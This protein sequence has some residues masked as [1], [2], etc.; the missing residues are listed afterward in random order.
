VTG[1]VA[2]PPALW[3]PSPE[4]VQNANLTRYL[5][6]LEQE[7]N[8]RFDGYDELWRWSTDDLAG[9]WSS[10][11]DHYAVSATT[12]PERI[13]SDHGMP[14]V[15]WF[16]GAT[17]NYAEHILR[18]GR[19]SAIAVLYA[20]EGEPLRHLTRGQLRD[21]VARLAQGL[22][23]MAVRPGD[24]VAAFLPNGAEAIV[25]VLACASL[26]AI[27]SSCSPD[28][29]VRS[30]VDR[31]AQIEPKVLIAADGYRYGG[32][33][34]DRRDVVER[35]RAEIPS[36]EHTVLVTHLDPDAS[37][38][39]ATSWTDLTRDPAELVF[40]AVPFEHP[41]WI[42]YSSGT[43]GVPKGIV[44][45][46][47]GMLL[48]HLKVTHLHLDAQA[49]DRVFWFTTTGWMMWNFLVGCLLTDA[50]IVLYDGNPG[51]PTLDA[52]W[53]LA[54]Q[55]EITTFGT[56]A[57]YIAGCINDDVE[58]KQGRNLRAL[59]AVGSTGSPLPPEGFEWIY[60]NL[61]SDTWLFS[62][63]GGS[64]VCTA[65]LGGCPLLPVYAGELQ[66]RA[67][68]AAIE[69]WDEH[70]RPLR[71]EVGE[72]VITRPMPCMPVALWGDPDDARYR[73]S[74]FSVY[75][76]VW[77]HGDWVT[78]TS[79]GTA[80]IHGRSD[81]TI[82]RGGVRMGTAEIYAAVLSLEEIVDALI[83]DVDGWMPLFVV[84]AAD[85]TLDETVI[86]RVAT[87][88][89]QDC[90]P[91]HVPSE[92]MQVAAVPRTLTGKLLE[93]PVKRI[94]SGVPAEQAASRDALINPDALDFF[95]ELAADRAR[96]SNVQ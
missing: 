83:V 26:G 19:D 34:F 52:L 64:D 42:L 51:F 79:R 40:E 8:L 43:T 39:G 67:L 73:D 93:V 56:S 25:G 15:D 35:L 11:W 57:S 37:L 36:L 60:E 69:S 10:I 14:D 80:V 48:E 58:P 78:I 3:R 23:R 63:S 38:P 75:P 82:N 5:R 41:L 47:G 85:S 33:E 94:L 50:A 95:A 76:G 12:P 54:E 17:L 44:H 32:R 74:Y 55:A 88:V 84:L 16:P 90:S 22:R 89:R 77:R 68:G 18:G 45:G 27:W 9:F 21:E 29:G 59:R 72:L 46:H 70:R 92:V 96:S 91:R 1:A 7:R 49:G 31:F 4:R 6:W 24:R 71:D 13:L 81:S 30:V 66:C 2:A 53:E 87:R 61:G 65:F 28:F 62:A 20:T 86:K